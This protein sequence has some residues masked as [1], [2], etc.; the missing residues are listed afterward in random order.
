MHQRFLV[1]A[2]ALAAATLVLL[3]SHRLWQRMGSPAIAV[4]EASGS[5]YDPTLLDPMLDPDPVLAE[6]DRN[7]FSHLVEELP[8]REAP[9]PEVHL[10]SLN[11]LSQ[12]TL[13]HRICRHDATIWHELESTLSD[14]TSEAD[15][16]SLATV[17]V[18]GCLAPARTETCAWARSALDEHATERLQVARQLL[19][20][21]T[22]DEAL[23]WLDREDAPPSALT[24][25]MSLREAL[26]D[27][28]L[29]LPAQLDRAIETLQVHDAMAGILGHY[30]EIT[31]IERALQSPSFD[32]DF[33]L[34]LHPE[35]RAQA[36]TSLELCAR[37]DGLT[38]EPCFRRLAAQDR[39]RASLV[40]APPRLAPL[41]PASFARFPTRA[42]IDEFLNAQGLPT[43]SRSH[44]PFVLSIDVLVA[45]G[46]AFPTANFERD[47]LAKTLHALLDAA[48]LTQAV[49]EVDA[50]GA[51][52]YNGGNVIDLTDS[53]L[54][55]I[56]AIYAFER[57]APD[58]A[59]ASCVFA[60]SDMPYII[61]AP[62]SALTQLASAGFFQTDATTP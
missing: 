27:L 30:A 1:L 44:P 10:T 4:N 6:G 42:S 5:F 19:A 28:P 60:W 37:S 2:I 35:M 16:V 7:D 14:S 61:C 34:R 12:P 8:V 40:M 29:R 33:A 36:L 13:Q 17:S 25:F 21:C 26:R 9:M 54:Q 31:D 57:I 22:D 24:Q 23:P 45:R 58:G 50:Q 56:V 49:V 32:V 38:A 39:T 43:S 15:A 53:P 18:Q 3:G 51:H 11:S 20:H 52:V 48:G 47:G 46:A 55:P 41:F 59:P 62:R